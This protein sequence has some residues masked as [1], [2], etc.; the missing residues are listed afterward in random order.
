M[1]RAENHS[2]GTLGWWGKEGG[3]A[4][5]PAAFDTP[6]QAG[7]GSPPPP[8]P[9][10]T[11][12]LFQQCPQFFVEDL[13]W[14][15]AFLT[16]HSRSFGGKGTRYKLPLCCFPSLPSYQHLTAPAGRGQKH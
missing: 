5:L 1:G 9:P 15:H 10:T 14:G 2:A 13:Q 12:T 4:S 8:R 6:T 3:Q 16:P 11:Y 7:K